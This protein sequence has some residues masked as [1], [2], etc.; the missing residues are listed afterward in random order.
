LIAD[1]GFIVFLLTAIFYINLKWAKSH[2]YTAIQT[3]CLFFLWFYHLTISLVFYQYILVHGGD[4]WRYWNIVESGETSM[5]NWF[6]LFGTGT[7]FIYWFN[8]P[9]SQIAGLGYLSGTILYASLSYFGFL[10]AFD[11]LKK[12]FPQFSKKTYAHPAFL[13]LLLPN[14]HFWSVGVGKESFLWLGLVLV[15]AGIY[16]FPNKFYLILLGLLLSLMT[17]PIQGLA[18]SI[19]VL[20]VI[21]FHEKLKPYR[22]KVFPVSILLILSIFA[23]RY[24]KGSLIYGFNLKWITDL[25]DWQRNFLA[26]FG[27]A[28]SIN[29]NDYSW[30]EKLITIFFRPFVWEVDG[31]WSIA[32]AMENVVVLSVFLLGV[33]SFFQLRGQFKISLYLWTVLIYGIIISLL[34]SLTLNNLGIIMRMKSIYFPFFS[35]IALHLFYKVAKVKVEK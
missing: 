29:M 35:I 23:Y 24:I 26:S 22:N 27:G 17:R 19:S 31:F 4:S 9:F 6:H 2:K 33:W 16:R 32:A 11:L 20:M 21:P 18:L 13:T 12:S 8:C 7:A 30:Y 25:L 5:G 28:S 34:F 14:V 3:K 1:I 15:L 10:L